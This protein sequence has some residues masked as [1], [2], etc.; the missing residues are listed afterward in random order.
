M[1]VAAAEKHRST[2]GQTFSMSAAGEDMWNVTAAPKGRPRL[3]WPVSTLSS[4]AR[5]AT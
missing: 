2:R 4:A 3:S 1:L 5:M